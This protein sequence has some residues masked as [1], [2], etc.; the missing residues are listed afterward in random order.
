MRCWRMPTRAPTPFMPPD[1][2]RP[3][4]ERG[5]PGAGGQRQPAGLRQRA[6]QHAHRQCRG[7]SAETAAPATTPTS[8]AIPAPPCLKTPAR[9]STPFMPRTTTASRPTWKTS[10]S[11]AAPTC[12]ATATRSSQHDL[13]QPQQQPAQRRRRRGPDGRR[14][15]QRHLFRR[16][17]GDFVLRETP[18]R[19]QTRCTPRCISTLTASV[20]NLV[21]DGSADLQ[22]YGNAVCEHAH[23]Q[24]RQQPAQRRRRRRHHARAAPATIPISSTTRATW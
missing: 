17:G 21:L 3:R 13:R 7:Q 18:T 2:Y 14:R 9:A 8:S 16:Q 23:R 6:R 5:E 10:C 11:T 20:E 1:H 19:A 12:R 15:R 22:G 4:G 24:Q